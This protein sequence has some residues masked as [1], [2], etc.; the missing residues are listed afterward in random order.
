[1][2][3]QLGENVTDTSHFEEDLETLIAYVHK[4]APR[5]KII[6]IG[7][8]WDKNRNEMRK[9]A[10]ENQSV[11]FADLSEIIG[12]KEYQSQ[13]GTIC[14]LDDGSTIAVSK[15]AATHPGDKGMEYIANKVIEE[16]H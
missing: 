7:D 4:R 5:A 3:I 15:E 11:L 6:V 10:A 13:K 2:T 12:N 14:T 8:F 9:Q 16:I 1:M